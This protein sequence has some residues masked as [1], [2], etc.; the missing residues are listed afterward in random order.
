LQESKEPEPLFVQAFLQVGEYSGQDFR[1]AEKPF[2]VTFA[3]EGG[4][5]NGGLC[6]LFLK[7]KNEN[8]P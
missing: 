3:N 2:E 1:A 8:W 6:I 5:D 7:E 4:T